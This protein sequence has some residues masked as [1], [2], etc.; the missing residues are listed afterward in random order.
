VKAKRVT[1]QAL[2]GQQGI[3]LIEQVVLRMG[4]IWNPTV[5][6]DVGI[7]GNIELCE[8]GTGR[9]L[10]IV[11]LVQSRAT[12]GE[13]QAE[14]DQSFE[15]LCSERELEYWMQGNAPVLLIRSRPSTNEAYWVSLKEYFG[16][17]AR[18]ATRLVRFDK[19]ANRFDEAAFD[20]LLA[21][22]GKPDS[23]LYLGPPTK[24][25]RLISNLLAVASYAPRVY[26]AVTTLRKADDLWKQAA[27]NSIR[28]EG[29]VV[30][31]G[32]FLV[33]FHDL[34]EWPW[35]QFCDRGSVEDFDTI[36][37]AESE[38]ADRRNEF[39]WL[40]RDSLRQKL[41]PQVVYRKDQEC[42]M[43]RAHPNLEPFSV[44]YEGQRGTSTRQVFTRRVSAKT[45]KVSWYRHD[46]F[47]GAFR[48]YR[49]QWYLEINPTYVFTVDGD[50]ISLFQGD[51]LSAI[52]RFERNSDVRRQ[53]LMWASYL[54]RGED[55]IN[56]AYPFLAFGDLLAVD[57][58]RGID[59]D[60]WEVKKSGDEAEA[61][62]SAQEVMEW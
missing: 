1:T 51:S 28:L 12:E 53:V 62:N 49:G 55:L 19:E 37:W 40:L 46:A 7:D 11:L 52:K 29:P 35:T 36:E 31:K 21:A 61:A 56:P 13:F 34:R 18:R 59:D 3:N 33:S 5:A 22:G 43:F 6:I 47:E 50:K 14:T 9:A 39:I 58:N 42:F 60:A 25:E 24:S 38:D 17:P 27:A 26:M 2:V 23:G 30:L 44:E 16:E 57:V 41:Y 20:R 54:G 4:S 10:G 48:H 15:Y 32:G 8:P 45:G